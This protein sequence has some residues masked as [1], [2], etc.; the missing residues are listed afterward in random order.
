MKGDTHLGGDDAR[1]GGL[2]EPGRT[3]EKDVVGGLAALLCRAEDDVE[4]F[5]QL[6]LADEFVEGARTEAC[7]IVDLGVRTETGIEELIPHGVPPA[8]RARRAAWTPS[9]R[10]SSVGA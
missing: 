7:L 8:S 9:P 2:A 5:L 10:R 6:A 1:H 3:R 4:M